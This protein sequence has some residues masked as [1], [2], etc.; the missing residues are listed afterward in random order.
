[1]REITAD[2]ITTTNN[3]SIPAYYDVTIEPE[4]NYLQKDL[5]KYFIQAG[6]EVTTDILAQEE[7][8]LTFILRKT[9]LLTNL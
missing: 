5:Q 8:V 1:M 2:A 4:V 9:R 7:T 3:A 6:M